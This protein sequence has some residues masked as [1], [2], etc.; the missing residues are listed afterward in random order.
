MLVSSIWVQFPELSLS[1]TDYWT[2]PLQTYVV[3]SNKYKTKSAGHCA[4]I[5]FANF[6]VQRFSATFFNFPKGEK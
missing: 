3:S 6:N 5:T 2:H 4:K 1:L